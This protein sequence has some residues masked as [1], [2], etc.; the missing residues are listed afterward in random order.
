MIGYP[1][2]SAGSKFPDVCSGVK[3]KSDMCKPSYSSV[4][5]KTL[6]SSLLYI[7]FYVLIAGHTFLV[8]SGIV[9]F[10]GRIQLHRFTK[11]KGA[12]PPHDNIACSDINEISLYQLFRPIIVLTQDCTLK[13]R[14]YKKIEHYKPVFKFNLYFAEKKCGR[15]G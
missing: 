8:Q 15:N 1:N 7:P 14:D 12:C 3:P 9:N 2:I 6:C 4:Y 11:F 10:R 5:C 13:I